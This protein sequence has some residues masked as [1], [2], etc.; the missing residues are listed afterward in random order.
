MRERWRQKL[1]DAATSGGQAADS[2]D[3][4]FR[5]GAVLMEMVIEEGAFVV[6]FPHGLDL[7]VKKPGWQSEMAVHVE[8]APEPKE[9]K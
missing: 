6:M 7:S 2:A 8:A 4:F 9:P 5:L 3:K 1:A